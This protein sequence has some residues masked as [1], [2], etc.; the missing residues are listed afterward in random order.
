MTR[1]QLSLFVAAMVVAAPPLFAQPAGA[2]S[3]R[4][5]AA[6]ASSSP[7]TA[8]AGSSSA[9]G[10]SAAKAASS[11][12]AAAVQ[13]QPVITPRQRQLADPDRVPVDI[14]AVSGELAK[15]LNVDRSRLPKVAWLPP[16]V[17]AAACG[18]APAQL[19]TGTTP[20]EQPAPACAAKRVSAELNEAVR[21]QMAAPA[22][23]AASR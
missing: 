13:T 5:A 8:A 19:P 18:V 20:R 16:S 3:S 11:D 12:P 7:A 14:A 15:S 10:S 23:R 2:G 21:Q 6:A 17:A 9:A 1:T 4:Q 22:S